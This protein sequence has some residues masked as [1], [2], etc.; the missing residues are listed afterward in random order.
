MNTEV[1]LA[2][3][4]V[5]GLLVGAANVM[6]TFRVSRNTAATAA[7]RETAL[8]YEAKSRA[9]EAEI[10][11]LRAEL[12]TAHAQIEGLSQ[13]VTMLQDMVTSRTLI[14]SLGHTLDGRWDTLMDKMNT[15][16]AMSAD[17]KTGVRDLASP[18]GESR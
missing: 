12:A 18:A 17:I 5:I 6:G 8:A 10:S 11:G 4:A 16:L 13:R 14:E 7:Y 9:Q 3:V 1:I 2:F 15:V